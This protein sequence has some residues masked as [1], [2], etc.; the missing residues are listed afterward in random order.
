[1]N[2]SS[3]RC[4]PHLRKGDKKGMVQY[5]CYLCFCGRP[6]ERRVDSKPSWK[7]TGHDFLFLFEFHRSIESRKDTL[8]QDVQHS[9]LAEPQK[10]RRFSCVPRKCQAPH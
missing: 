1:M 9:T 3:S 2:D 6:R 4:G 5:S 8:L 10:N 7:I